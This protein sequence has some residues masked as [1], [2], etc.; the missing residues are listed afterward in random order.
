[1]SPT[2]ARWILTLQSDTL[3]TDTSDLDLVF[4]SSIF[5]FICIRKAQV[6]YSSIVNQ[7][8]LKVSSAIK[9]NSNFSTKG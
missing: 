4:T 6:L 1:M 5:S 2:P 7:H 8:I 3:E 9:I